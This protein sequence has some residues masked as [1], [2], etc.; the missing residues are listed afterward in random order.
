M[1]VRPPVP[2]FD[3]DSAAQK[4]QSAEDAWNTRDPDRVAS[5]YTQDSRW[6]NR[7][8]FIVGHDAIV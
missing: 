7:D 8:T 5:A 6:R 3:K 2:P 1:S 4:V